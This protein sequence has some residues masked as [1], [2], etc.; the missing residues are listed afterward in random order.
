M[1]KKVKL[2]YPEEKKNLSNR[3]LKASTINYSSFPL[4]DFLTPS[5]PLSKEIS[6]SEE[7]ILEKGTKNE[8]KILEEDKITSEQIKIRAYEEGFREGFAEGQ[9]HGYAEGLKKGMEEGIERGYQEGL[10]KAKEEIE[11]LKEKLTQDLNKEV[12]ALRSFLLKLDEEAKKL[13][14]NLDQEV[15]TFALSLV[16]SLFFKKPPIDEEMLLHLIRQ[17]LKYIAEGLKVEIRIHPEDLALL[18]RNLNGLPPTHQF[19]FKEDPTLSRG[20]IILTSTAGVVDATLETRLKTLF[21][22]F[23]NES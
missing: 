4:K 14:L 1:N 18:Q 9:K 22:H 2:S 10:K 16:E 13:I 7:E 12:D 3:I 17:A 5:L 23:A 19:E 11:A 8:K 6:S 15:L 20:G 21:S